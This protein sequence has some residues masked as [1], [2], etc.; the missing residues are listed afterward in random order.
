[1]DQLVERLEHVVE[2]AQLA[3][4]VGEIELNLVAILEVGKLALDPVVDLDR[5]L[6]EQAR[7]RGD[8]R[9]VPLL[10]RL[11][12]EIV[13]VAPLLP[14]ELRE[15]DLQLAQIPGMSRLRDQ[16][17]RLTAQYADL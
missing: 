17:A 11:R 14:V 8:H 6:L 12:L 15:P 3:H 1:M 4:L 9:P 5:L 7:L 10:P 16:L 2:V 13:D